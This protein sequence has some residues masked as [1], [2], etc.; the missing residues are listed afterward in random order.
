MIPVLLVLLTIAVVAVTV[1]VARRSRRSGGAGVDVPSVPVPT[2]VSEDIIGASSAQV[3]AVVG[4]TGCGKS[5]LVRFLLDRFLQANPARRVLLIDRYAPDH[6]QID[7]WAATRG[8]TW[9]VA[10]SPPT[11]RGATVR[12]DELAHRLT[13]VGDPGKI[14]IF[15]LREHDL[16]VLD[17]SLPEKTRAQLS[18]VI[19]SPAR[20]VFT[21]QSARDLKGME[22]AEIIWMS[23]AHGTEIQQALTTVRGSHA[24]YLAAGQRH[25]WSIPRAEAW[26]LDG[27]FRGVEQRIIDWLDSLPVGEVRFRGTLE[28]LLATAPNARVQAACFRVLGGIAAQGDRPALLTAR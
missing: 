3:M 8:W 19:G 25:R 17:E 4:Q 11:I 15:A 7:A 13:I 9:S 22:P 24:E 2:S 27:D 14:P 21:A 23:G 6:L 12:P 16:V 26:W 18:A 28:H 10:A 1:I 20:I 5:V